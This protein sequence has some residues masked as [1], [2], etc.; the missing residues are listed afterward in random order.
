MAV[1]RERVR[2]ALA[3]P[4]FLLLLLCAVLAGCS[5]GDDSGDE[6]ASALPADNSADGVIVPRD[7]ELPAVPTDGDARGDEPQAAALPVVHAEILTAAVTVRVEDVV[8]AARRAE[9]AALTAGGSVGGTETR[10]D[11][12][13][14]ASTTARLNLRVPNDE[15]PP[16]LRTLADLGTRVSEDRSVQDVTAEVADVES[17]LA[18]QRASIERLR[19]FLR[20]ASSIEDVLR[21]E[22]DLTRREADLE[23]LQARSRALADRTSLASVDLTLVSA[24]A[25]AP[26]AEREVDSGFLAGLEGGW[27]AFVGATAVTLTVLGAVLPFA[28]LAALVGVPAYRMRARFRRP[29]PA[30]SSAA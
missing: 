29:A 12:A 25:P 2:R 16:F 15:V 8:A 6:A 21:I 4:A 20:E 17:R 9:D 23:A 1:R 28:V 10:V 22:S 26:A 14:P 7:P 24:T 27:D 19:G 13:D 3:G 11:P 30:D 18:N 5:G